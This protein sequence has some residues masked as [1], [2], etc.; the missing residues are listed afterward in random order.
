MK[1]LFKRDLALGYEELSIRSTI[2]LKHRPNCLTWRMYY[3]LSVFLVQGSLFVRKTDQI[4]RG[5]YANP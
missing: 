2:E 5:E 1:H 4:I 3:L